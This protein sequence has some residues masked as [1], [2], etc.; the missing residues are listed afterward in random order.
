MKKKL[1]CWLLAKG[2]IQRTVKKG[3]REKSCKTYLISVFFWAPWWRRWRRQDKACFPILFS[4]FF[5]SFYASDSQGIFDLQAFPLVNFP[6]SPLDPLNVTKDL[7][8]FWHK[9]RRG[10][11][12]DFV[13]RARI[14]MTHWRDLM[15]RA[16]KQWRI[17][18]VVADRPP[19]RE[20]TR[21]KYRFPVY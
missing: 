13:K 21:K 2:W 9:S 15:Q 6:P 8:K 19:D 3:E 5:F 4:I 20:R 18:E 7:S 14:T 17:C 10:S 16:I 1:I 11:M 12:A